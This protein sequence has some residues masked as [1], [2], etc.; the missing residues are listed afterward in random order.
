MN[1]LDIFLCYFYFGL[2]LMLGSSQVKV[3]TFL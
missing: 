3:T 2:Y 1:F